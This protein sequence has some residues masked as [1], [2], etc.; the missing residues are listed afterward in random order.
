MQDITAVDY[1]QNAY[2]W[3][4]DAGQVLETLTLAPNAVRH[5]YVWQDGTVSDLGSLGG[6][7]TV[8]VAINARGQV[9]RWSSTST[10]A[11]YAFMWQ[12][13][14]MRDLGTLGGATSDPTAIN[15][16]GEIVGSSSTANGAQ[17]PFLWR[18]NVMR[19]LGTLDEAAMS[20]SAATAI[21]D[22]GLIVG[23]SPIAGGP[24]VRHVVRWR[25]GVISEIGPGRPAWDVSQLNNRGQA[26]LG[27]EGSDGFPHTL[28]WND[29][30]GTSHDIG[31]HDFD[32]D[33][34][35]DRG[36]IIFNTKDRPIGGLPKPFIY[37]Q[38][39]AWIL[40]SLGERGPEAVDMNE[41]DQIVGL[42]WLPERV[43]V[44]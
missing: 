24:D 2:A 15:A 35:N 10:G 6:R 39:R 16:N 44:Q 40:G 5:S 34:I 14:T 19:D 21:N 37:E 13:G 33:V 31:Y 3:I 12:A 25:N 23:I 4:N 11:Q 38:G 9:I 36:Q 22:H 17:H 20:T 18:D 43:P 42:A 28:V 8:G 7:E 29:A 41:H 1:A 26:L 30:S 27:V 32:H